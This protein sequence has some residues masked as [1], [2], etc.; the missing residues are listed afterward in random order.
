MGFTVKL[1]VTK[2]YWL[3]MEADIAMDEKTAQKARKLK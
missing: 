1:C 3:V 2:D